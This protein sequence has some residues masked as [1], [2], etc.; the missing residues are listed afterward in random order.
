VWNHSNFWAL[1]NSEAKVSDVSCE[2]IR[3]N[4]CVAPC[5]VF[6]AIL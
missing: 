6:Q 3:I 2:G 4:C 1:H 5:D